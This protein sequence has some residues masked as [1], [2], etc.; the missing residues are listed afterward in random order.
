MLCAGDYGGV[1][2]PAGAG[3][4]DACRSRTSARD[5]LERRGVHLGL[6][7]KDLRV[8][9]RHR[10]APLAQEPQA[11]ETIKKPSYSLVAYG[12]G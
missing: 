4:R 7:G 5:R 1:E 8:L 10:E 12:L 11:S 2:T 9:D 3:E 6:H